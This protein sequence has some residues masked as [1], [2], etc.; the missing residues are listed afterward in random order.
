M[1]NQTKFASPL[2][3]FLMPIL[4]GIGIQSLGY[5][6]RRFAI[7]PAGN[8]GKSEKASPAKQKPEA[9]KEF[10][11][12]PSKQNGGI[13]LNPQDTADQN[14]GVAADPPATYDPENAEEII[15]PKG[16][17]AL[18]VALETPPKTL[19]TIRFHSK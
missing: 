18:E 12:T 8:T 17:P 15:S 13:S 4:F 2:I 10:N 7:L 14:E 11:C 19:P 9:S 6:T 5:D 16:P 3:L 1:N